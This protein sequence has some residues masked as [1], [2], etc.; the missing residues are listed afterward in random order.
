MKAI[1]TAA[2]AKRRA[3]RDLVREAMA[4]KGDARRRLLAR[5]GKAIADEPKW[6]TKATHRIEGGRLQPGVRSLLGTEHEPLLPQ[7]V[8]TRI[9]PY[10]DI[11][12]VTIDCVDRT[13][14]CVGD[15]LL[16]PFEKEPALAAFERA[17]TAPG[18]SS[19]SEPAR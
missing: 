1:K 7:P 11:V 5:I 15:G 2:K 14:V 18:L 16:A 13:M 6:H 8:S 3:D 17:V 12:D 9:N 4:N 10:Q 19:L